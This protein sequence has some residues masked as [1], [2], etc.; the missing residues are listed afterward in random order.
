MHEPGPIVADERL[1]EISGIAFSRADERVLYA[2]NDSGDVA[3]VFALA[4]DGTTTEV[5]TADAVALD[6]EDAATTA[7]AVFLADIGDN[8][9][10]RPSVRILRIDETTRVPTTYSITYPGGRPDAEALIVDETGSVATIIT[11]DGPD[12]RA[13]IFE[14]VLDENA[15]VAEA[16]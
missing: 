10:I 12:G 16:V 5:L 1:T 2:H 13:R 11:K 15:D 8:L 14:V 9:G 7:D 6:W 3:R 4:A